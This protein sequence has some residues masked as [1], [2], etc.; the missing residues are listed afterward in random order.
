[1]QINEQPYDRNERGSR[2]ERCDEIMSVVNQKTTDVYNAGGCRVQ[3]SQ[4]L[5][6]AEA[7]ETPLKSAATQL[8][9]ILL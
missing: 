5:M 6:I 2:T 4:E 7:G 8:N 1:M 3:H 9:H